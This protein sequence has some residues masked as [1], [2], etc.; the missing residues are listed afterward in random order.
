MNV[1]SLISGFIELF[2]VIIYK[3][4]SIIIPMFIE[5]CELNIEIAHRA[6]IRKVLPLKMLH[7]FSKDKKIFSSLKTRIIHFCL[8]LLN[9]FFELFRKA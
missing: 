1:F 9:L 6:V 8:I 3:T 5:I 2:K 7:F 4:Y